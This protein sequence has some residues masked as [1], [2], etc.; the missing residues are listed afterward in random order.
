MDSSQLLAAAHRRAMSLGIICV[1]DTSA[2]AG[3]R[4]APF[5]E[6]CFA[7]PEHGA[8][9]VFATFFV[10]GR[11]GTLIAVRRAKD[12]TLSLIRS[13]RVDDAHTIYGKTYDG[14]IFDNRGAVP[15]VRGADAVFDCHHLNDEAAGAANNYRLVRAE[16]VE[17]RVTS[18]GSDPLVNHEKHYWE[19]GRD[20]GSVSNP[21]IANQRI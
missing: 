17:V 15:C 11:A 6:F 16:I 5:T 14:A 3:V 19:L 1:R 10:N 12:F 13:D 2:R 4:A 21:A 9:S 20:L 7:L 8:A 18:E